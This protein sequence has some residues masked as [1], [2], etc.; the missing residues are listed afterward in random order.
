MHAGKKFGSK[1]F[2]K[3]KFLNFQRM[4]F[5]ENWSW[6]NGKDIENLIETCK[7]TQKMKNIMKRIVHQ[8]GHAGE[9]PVSVTETALLMVLVLLLFSLNFS[10]HSPCVFF[11]CP[12]LVY[13]LCL[14]F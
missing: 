13:E 11:L 10:S 2:I 9:G 8:A 14:I 5:K 7:F 4:K 1:K 12:I 6:F 3:I